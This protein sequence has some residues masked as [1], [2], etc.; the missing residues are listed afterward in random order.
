MFRLDDSTEK[1]VKYQK[2][3]YLSNERYKTL[4][5]RVSELQSTIAELKEKF[6]LS[7]EQISCLQ[8]SALD[9]QSTNQAQSHQ[10]DFTG[11]YCPETPG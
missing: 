1:G 3:Y 11:L 9:I 8:N 2:R 5:V 6:Q 4:G 10:E 7:A